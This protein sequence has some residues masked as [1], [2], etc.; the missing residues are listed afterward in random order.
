LS[1]AGKIR[2]YPVRL[3]PRLNKNFFNVNSEAV[4]PVSSS[5]L[6]GPTWICKF[7]GKDLMTKYSLA[8]H[9]STLFIFL[10]G[11]RGRR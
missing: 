2:L 6:E 9:V 3:C 5:V 10:R 11:R 1:K 8:S 4:R 7:C